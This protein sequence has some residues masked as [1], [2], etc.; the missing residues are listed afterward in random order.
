M[1]DWEQVGF[2]S[3]SATYSVTYFVDFSTFKIKDNNKRRVLYYGDVIYMNPP[4]AFSI[5]I[6]TEVDCEAEEMTELS[7]SQYKELGLKG[8][9]AST[10][11]D[12]LKKNE[13]QTPRTNGY[14]VF[15]AICK[16]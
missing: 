13:I 14:K 15:S 3:D 5:K 11:Q 6:Y 1:A 16:H 12:M 9:S 4:L 10:P 2:D 8:A 7:N